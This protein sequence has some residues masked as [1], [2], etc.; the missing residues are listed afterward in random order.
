MNLPSLP[1]LALAASIAISAFMLQASCA[2]S[3]DDPLPDEGALF[4]PDAGKPVTQKL[5]VQ[6]ECPP[7]WASCPGDGLCTT[8]LT[9]DVKNCGAC[10]VTCPRL[11]STMHATA[12]C[13]AGKCTY[14]CDELFADCNG[15]TKD[16][17]ETDIAADPKNCGGCGITCKEGVICWRGACGCPSGMTQCGD[18]CKKLDSDIN[19]CGACNQPCRPPPADDTRWLCGPLVTPN[20]TEWQCTTG[21]CT[22]QCKSGFGDCNTQFCADGC[23]IDLLSDPNNCGACGNKCEAGQ[24]CNMGQCICP[25]GTTRC[26]DDCVDTKIDPLNCGRCGYRCPGPAAI[27]NGKLAT[28]SPSCDLGECKYTCYPPFADCDGLL[29]NGCEVNLTNNNRNCGACG[30][31]CNVAQ[32]QPCVAGA[33]LTKE[34]DAGALPR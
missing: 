26:G 11:R 9:N 10:G 27:R 16:G 31:E 29:S 15:D 28:G 32:S 7:P 3:G 5:C 30:N 34:C 2:T 21:N 1:R 19:H 13:A 6:N 24:A 20:N 22:L 17:C 23:E 18:D 33:C 12:L 4:T 8:N 14:A 25:S